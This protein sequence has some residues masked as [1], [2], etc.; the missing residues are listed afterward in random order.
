MNEH[1]DSKHCCDVTYHALHKWYESEFEKLGWMVLA[2]NR[3]LTDKIIEYL[4]SLDRLHYS[5]QHKMTHIKDKDK[6][7]DLELMCHNV[8]LLIEHAKKDF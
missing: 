4:A 2:K 7:H 1:E 3:G 6:R 8:D 5:L